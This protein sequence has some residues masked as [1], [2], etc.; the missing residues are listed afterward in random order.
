MG[1]YS[2]WSTGV[3]DPTWLSKCVGDSLSILGPNIE[4]LVQRHRSTLVVASSPHFHLSN[5]PNLRDLTLD[6]GVWAKVSWDKASGE[7]VRDL[8]A[9]CTKITHLELAMPSQKSLE[10][11]LSCLPP[12]LQLHH[13]ALRNI[14]VD[15][16]S[17]HSIAQNFN[18]ARLKS[19][20]CGGLS[21]RHV[22]QSPS[23]WEVLATKGVQLEAIHTSHHHIS[24][25]KYIAQL[26]GET[27]RKIQMHS[28]T[29]RTL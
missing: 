28:V 20:D 10:V 19:F 26:P 5:L 22:R 13:L 3:L 1:D 21:E 9:T 6:L 27:L 25:I 7:K 15:G 8:L 18:L 14:I 16:T 2:R 12:A 4:E 17:L 24:L 23:I 29:S 11:V